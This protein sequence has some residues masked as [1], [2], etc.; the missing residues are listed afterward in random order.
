MAPLRRIR[1]FYSGSIFNPSLPGPWHRNYM[2]ASAARPTDGDVIDQFLGAVRGNGIDID[3][4]IIADGKIHRYHAAG[5]RRNTRN[6][7]A[8]LHIDA[9]PAGKYGSWKTGETYTWQ[10]NGGREIT[11][12][13]RRLMKEIARDRAKERKIETEKDQAE[14]KIRAEWLYNNARPVDIHPYLT[15]KGVQSNPRLRV[16]EWRYIDEETGEDIV[17][18]SDALLVPLMDFAGNIHSLQAILSDKEG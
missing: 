6:A 17:I 13:E 9:H 2:V 4:A 15:Y 10:M 16:G 11:A 18:A 14:A 12:E 3:E 5:D 7:W 1:N 8:V